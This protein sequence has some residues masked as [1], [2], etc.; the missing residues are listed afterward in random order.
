MLFSKLA[1]ADL[2][3]SEFGPL[4]LLK[5]LLDTKICQI[6][7]ARGNSCG[8]CISREACRRPH[9]SFDAAQT[10]DRRPANFTLSRLGYRRPWLGA[11]ALRLLLAEAPV[12]ILLQITCSD[13]IKGSGSKSPLISHTSRNNPF[14]AAVPHISS[15]RNE[16]WS[17]HSH[18]TASFCW[19]SVCRVLHSFHL[20]EVV[21]S[22]IVWIVWQLFLHTWCW[23]ESSILYYPTQT[24]CLASWWIRSPEAQNSAEIVYLKYQSL[25]QHYHSNLNPFHI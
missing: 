3:D 6:H 16:T 20:M 12:E 10:Y 24:I 4:K 17:S 22:S 5:N 21:V 15:C 23:R 14:D 13:K 8:I 25:C 11:A 2:G 7:E 19:A 9:L 1:V 18:C